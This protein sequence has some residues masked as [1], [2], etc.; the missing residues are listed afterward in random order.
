MTDDVTVINEREGFIKCPLCPVGYL[1]DVRDSRPTTVHGIESV[2]RRRICTTC[3]ARSTTY[4][5]PGHVF[6]RMFRM[7]GA[8]HA[9]AT[10]IVDIIDGEVRAEMQR[11]I[12]G[13]PDGTTLTP[14]EEDIM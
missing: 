1:K 6:E 13:S 14:R 10:R 9:L 8:K 5:I 3:G 12:R 4:E 2:R 11:L 7:Q